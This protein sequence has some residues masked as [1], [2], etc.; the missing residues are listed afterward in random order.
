M[1]IHRPGQEIGRDLAEDN[2]VEDNLACSFHFEADKSVK[3][4]GNRK[5]DE[6]SFREKWE[7]V[8]GE[9]V[10]RF[11]ETHPLAGKRRVIRV[12]GGGAP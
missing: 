2:R 8:T 7:Q 10:K 6:E 3:S 5:V 12:K 11:G 1:Q 9:I 4:Q